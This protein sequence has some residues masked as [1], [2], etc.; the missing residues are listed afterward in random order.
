M[1]TYYK[2]IIFEQTRKMKPPFVF[3]KIAV[4]E[5]FTNR[6]EDTAFLIQ[7]FEALN[8]VILIAPRRWGKSSLVKHATK[9]L[10]KKNKKFKIVYLDLFNVK[11]ESEFYN[12]LAVEVIKANTS[13][14]EDLVKKSGQFFKNIIP[15]ISFS[16]MP[17]A[18]F[19][20]SLDWEEVQ[21]HKGE[22]L[23]MAEN[24]SK[25][26]ETKTLICIDEFQNIGFFE[27]P[28]S[29]QKELR[30]YWQQHQNVSY[31]IYGSREHMMREV[32]SNK[33]MPFYKF[34]QVIN[35]DKIKKEKWIPFIL[36]RFSDTN[37]T[38]SSESA[39]YIIELADN[40]PYYVQQ[41]A[42]LSWMNTI[43][44]CDNNIIYSAL[45]NLINQS[46]PFYL[47]EMENISRSQSNFLNLL[48][49]DE[50]EYTTSRII[51]KYSLNTSANVV[52]VRKALEEKDVIRYENK[53][54][55]FV[56]P[57]LKI[58]LKMI[59]FT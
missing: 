28:L 35:L 29:F 45:E 15:K 21:K 43:D 7:N 38:I 47:R 14:L 22:I 16:P 8:T 1:V 20:L 57:M 51:K 52:K 12:K 34:G 39:T 24:L 10:A 59:Y 41:L 27:N 11:S 50:K 5:E 37:K 4:N 9:E 48:V 33:K 36:K 13:K 31:C 32:F 46:H 55:L 26:S 42:Q 2:N 23:D 17:D 49:N 3:G 56:D 6:E 44:I 58:W 53:N 25:Q 54:I 18:E 30:S 40:H 19:A